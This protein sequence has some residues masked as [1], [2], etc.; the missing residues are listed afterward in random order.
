MSKV[1]I[2]SYFL[3]QVPQLQLQGSIVKKPSQGEQFNVKLHCIDFGH[4]H[5]GG[6]SQS[7]TF[8]LNKSGQIWLHVVGHTKKHP[9]GLKNGKA[10]PAN[11][12]EMKINMFI[13]PKTKIFIVNNQ[14]QI[15]KNRSF[16]KENNYIY[17]SMWNEKL[18]LFRVRKKCSM[19]N[20]YYFLFIIL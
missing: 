2:Y 5:F 20:I 11:K 3:V 1:H 7:Q 13:V 9:K 6:Q 16:D 10:S 15:I 4:S 14:L 12:N 19:S 17:L 18:L 8:G